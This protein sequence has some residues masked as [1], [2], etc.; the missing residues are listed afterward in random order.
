MLN[1]SHAGWRCRTRVHL[2][3]V[4]GPLPRGSG[5]TIWYE[6]DNLGRRL[7]FVQWDNG[8][9]VPVFPHEI[10]LQEQEAD[11]WPL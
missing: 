7:V 11:R 8:M 10:E 9:R 5:G 4:E 3:T 2:E 6:M 1:R